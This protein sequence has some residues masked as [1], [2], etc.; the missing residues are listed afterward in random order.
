[1]ALKQFKDADGNI[2]EVD[3][4]IS[5]IGP[6]PDIPKPPTTEAH[7][8]RIIPRQITATK[9]GEPMS[10]KNWRTW[11]PDPEEPKNASNTGLNDPAYR[12]LMGWD[13]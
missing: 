8:P 3:D 6:A 13:K 1:M 2:V 7:P 11:K 12:K 9:K 10:E 5:L 4:E